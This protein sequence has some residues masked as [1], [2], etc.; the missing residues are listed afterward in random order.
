MDTDSGLPS[1]RWFCP[2]ALSPSTPGSPAGACDRGYPAD[3]GFI[4]F[5]RLATPMFA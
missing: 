3:A 1:S 5:G 2:R 4:T